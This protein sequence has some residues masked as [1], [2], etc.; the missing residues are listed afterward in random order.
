[1]WQNPNTRYNR[2]WESPN[3]PYDPNT[4]YDREWE[5]G[6]SFYNKESQNWNNRFRSLPQEDIYQENTYEA[7][8]SNNRTLDEIEDAKDAKRKLTD[9]ITNHETHYSDDTLRELTDIIR[10]VNPIESDYFK[11]KIRYE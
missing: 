9:Y 2:E 3:I 10:K 4:R 11:S 6:N 1:M 8:F 7:M 5:S